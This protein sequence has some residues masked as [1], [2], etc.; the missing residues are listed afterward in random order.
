M[1]MACEDGPQISTHKMVLASSSPFFME[2]LKRNKHPHPLIYM[3]GLKAKDLVDMFDFVNHGPRQSYA[4]LVAIFRILACL[5]NK[6]STM[7][8]AAVQSGGHV[9]VGLL[10]LANICE[11]IKPETR[12][13]GSQVFSQQL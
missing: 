12:T 6:M 5:E 3:R 11:I 2:M 9:E 13:R 8:H 1:I 4:R 10:K 7:I